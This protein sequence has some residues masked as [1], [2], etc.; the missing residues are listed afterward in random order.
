M[1]VNIHDKAHELAQ[2]LKQT[3]EYREMMEL[4]ELVYQD[5]TNKQLLEEY[6]RLQMRL[7]AASAG[8]AQPQPEEVQ[9]M[10]AI[11]GL[12]QLN[13]DIGRYMMAEFRFQ[14]L[15]SDVFKILGDVA[16]IDIDSLGGA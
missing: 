6:K 12:M 3:D 9:R 5:D 7:M 14:R 2:A 11:A 10:Q 16:G 13:Q 4:K 1:Q 8:G 15:L